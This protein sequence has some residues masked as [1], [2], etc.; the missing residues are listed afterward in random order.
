MMRRDIA[1]ALCVFNHDVKVKERQQRVRTRRSQ[2][3]IVDDEHLLLV[4]KIPQGVVRGFDTHVIRV[5]IR[6]VYM[7]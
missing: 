6:S 2:F 4:V 1:L 5:S 7:A 3:I